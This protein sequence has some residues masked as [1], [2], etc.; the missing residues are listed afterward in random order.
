ML[1]HSIAS[2][3]HLIDILRTE[4][5]PRDHDQAVLRVYN[6]LDNLL[7]S[8]VLHTSSYLMAGLPSG[9]LLY[10]S[11]VIMWFVSTRTTKHVQVTSLSGW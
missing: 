3:C 7:S 5:K 6:L 1:H 8:G 4:G 10:L 9:F 11:S 2:K